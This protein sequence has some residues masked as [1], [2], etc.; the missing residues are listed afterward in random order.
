MN[1][2]IIGSGLTGLSAAFCLKDE[3]NIE[4]FEKRE[5]S[6]GC[7]SSSK[8]KKGYIED[9]YHHFFEGDEHLISLIEDLGL[10]TDMEWLKG[11]TG[12]HVNGKN[13]PLT[14]ITE[15]IRYP[16]MTFLDKFRLGMLTIKSG[17]YDINK[18]DGVTAKEFIETECGESVYSSFFEPLLKSKSGEYSDLVSAAWLVSRI[19]IRSNRKSGG[20]KLGYLKSGF[21]T[22]IKALEDEISRSGGIIHTSTP[23]EQISRSENGWIVNG[24]EFD[25]IINTINPQKFHRIGGPDSGEFTYQG[26]ACMTLGLKRDVLD[27]LYWVN[28]KDGA[29]Y[30]AVIGHTNFVPYERYDEHIVYLASYYSGKTPEGLQEKMLDDFKNRF[31]LNE[32]EILWNRIFIEDDA[33]PVYTTGYRSKIPGY[34]IEGIYYAGMFSETNYPERS[35]EGSIAA[36]KVVADEIRSTYSND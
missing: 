29:P 1:I 24:R 31:N 19:A 8:T 15:I 33:G 20:E 22:L 36:G 16:Y 7:L 28:M 26:A 9:F 23:V 35:M 4:L 2:C 30:G 10:K 13:E 27:G 6:G 12:Y 3:F 25:I 5:K 18:L 11:S 17:R 34:C 14:T 21:Q 32:N